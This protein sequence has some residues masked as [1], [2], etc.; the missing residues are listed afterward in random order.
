MGEP[1][2]E[3]VREAL[4]WSADILDL[5]A[6]D[7]PPWVYKILITTTRLWVDAA[8]PDIEAARNILYPSIDGT[9]VADD[10]GWVETRAAIAAAFGDNNLI[11][12]ANK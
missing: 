8:E 6:D 1:T 2:V 10:V 11:R 4:K 7:V 9:P 12:R 5:R 3:E